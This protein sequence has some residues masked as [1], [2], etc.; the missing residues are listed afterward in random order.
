M[1][2]TLPLFRCIAHPVKA[3]LVYIQFEPFPGQVEVGDLELALEDILGVREFG[4]L[5]HQCLVGSK[6][7]LGLS[8]GLVT[9]TEQVLGLGRIIRQRPDLDRAAGSL[10]GEAKIL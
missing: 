8:L 2:Q 10:D 7:L 6:R 4:V 1:G 9:A 5:L 3:V